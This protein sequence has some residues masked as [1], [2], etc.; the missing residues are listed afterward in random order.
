MV[1]PDSEDRKLNQQ[2]FGQHASNF[3]RSNAHA[4]GYSLSRLIELINPQAGWWALD[5]ATGGG[6]VA[7]VMARSV[8]QV[9]ASDLT[10]RMLLVA[11][12]HLSDSGV[13]N[14][15]YCG[16]AAEQL[17][18][19]DS[20]F[21]C[22][23]CRI[24]PHHF[25]DV[26]AFVQEA[27]RVLRPGGILAVADNVVSGEAKIARVVNIIDRFRDP[28]HQ[29]TYSLD[30]WE[31]FF[32]S[33]GLSV[34]HTEVFDK[35]TDVDEWASRLG[36]AGDDLTRL[37]ALILQTPVSTRNWIVPRQVGNRNLFN[38]T[39]AIIVGVK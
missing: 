16:A 9:V 24:A 21:D 32:Y 28:S 13:F 23:T 35:E 19:P 31:T 26:A 5:I 29:Q 22:V 3:V 7:L 33:A 6:H 14:V 1:S 17:P 27:T 8:E 38:I 10:H 20:I 30:D 18:Y 12:Q 25:L 4:R 2:Q 15:A 36:I 11:R 37:H 34:T 39:E